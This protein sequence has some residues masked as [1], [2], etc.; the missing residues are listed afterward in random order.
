[1]I[2]Y[3]PFFRGLY[4]EKE[5][6]PTH[7]FTF[8]LSLAW[9]VYKF[10][11][12]NYKIITTY[13]DVFAIALIFVY[14]VSIFYGVNTRLAIAEFLKYANY[15]FIF[16]L[17]RDLSVKG[18]RANILLNVMII[19]SII[20]AIIGIG[21]AIGTWDYNGA[22]VDGRINSTLQYPNTLASY[23]AALFIISTGLLINEERRIYKG[24]YGLAS[25]ILFF[26]FILTYSRG[27]WLLFPI[28]LLLYMIAVPVN[29]KTETFA[30]LVANMIIAIL[31]AFMFSKNIDSKD[32]LLWVTFIASFLLSGIVTYLIAYSEKILRKISIRKLSIFLAVV[33]AIIII[34]TVYLSSITVPLKLYN[35]TDKD[36]WNRVIRNVENV[37]SNT[38]YQLLIDYDISNKANRPYAGQVRIYSVDLEGELKIIDQYNISNQ[39]AKP[40]NIEFRTFEDTEMLKVYFVNYYANTSILFNE[41]KLL[42]SDTKEII[43]TIPLKYKYIPESIVSRIENI[44]LKNNSAQGRLTFYKDA[45]KIIKDNFIFG[46]GGGGWVTLYPIYQSYMYYTTQAHNYYFQMWIEVGVIGILIFLGMIISLTYNAY[47]KYRVLDDDKKMFVVSIYIPVLSILAHAFMDFDLSLSAL[48][49]I[50]WS[51]IGVLVG[52]GKETHQNNSS[53][54]DIVKLFKIKNNKIFKGIAIVLLFSLVVTSSTLYLGNLYARKALAANNEK[55][56]DDAIKYFEKASAYDPFKAE[57]K[58]DL[59]TFYKIKYKLTKDSQNIIKAQELIEKALKLGEYDS[60][61]NALGASFY[62][63]I[64]NLDK[65]LELIDKSVELQPMKVENYIQKCDGYITVFGYYINQKEDFKRAEEVIERAYKIKEDIKKV[66]EYALRPLEYNEELLTKLGLIQFNY[67]N[68][69]STEY[70]LP[71]DYIVNFSYYFDLDIDNNNIIDKLVINDNTTVENRDNH[72]RM[73]ANGEDTTRIDIEDLNLQPN[74]EYKIYLKVRGTIDGHN[75][76]ANIGDK[77]TQTQLGKLQGIDLTSEWQLVDFNIETNSSIEP[78]TQYISL[79]ITGEKNEYLDIEEIV[80][81]EKIS[82]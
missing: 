73:V 23:L 77:K 61:F 25:N 5:L 62:I 52:Y 19:S 10:R 24:I 8:I 65:G 44:T 35:N 34:L 38:S 9:L 53:K 70:I 58:M 17:S 20:V 16:L 41:V 6:I 74:T 21:S 12:K 13:I 45:F 79:E 60:R 49:I 30:Y 43:E 69:K 32:I 54:V 31:F 80:I 33:L 39:S 76:N 18:K 56:I 51:L 71:K 55:N 48:A 82:Q 2:F 64:G 40:L 11:D 37:Q 47:K 75:F 26:T 15:F 63:S 67:E 59:S 42:T 57:Y 22:F 72:I 78:G 27:M 81:F 50:L 7:I 1:M 3:P 14:F 29:K 46:T 28:I 66:N 68:I 4:F 36:I